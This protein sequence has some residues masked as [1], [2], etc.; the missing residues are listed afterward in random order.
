MAGVAQAPPPARRPTVYTDSTASG[1]Q[2]TGSRAGPPAQSVADRR[3]HR[4]QRRA[5]NTFRWRPT[6]PPSAWDP[7]PQ[8]TGPALTQQHCSGKGLNCHSPSPWASR[9]GRLSGSRGPKGARTSDP[10][11]WDAPRGISFGHFPGGATPR[12]WTPTTPPTNCWPEAPWGGG[13]GGGHGRGG[14][15]MAGGGQGGAN[16]G[17]GSRRVGWGGGPGGAM[18][19]TPLATNCWPKAPKGG[20]GGAGV[21][22]VLGPAESPPPPPPGGHLK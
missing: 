20:G 1:W 6:S 19:A 12:F 21:V 8:R 17:G 11:T 10:A 4:M 5:A 9:C 14:G 16:G 13:G 3:P 18:R 7:R 15:G 22:G 2:P